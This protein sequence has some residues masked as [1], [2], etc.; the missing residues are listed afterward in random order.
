MHL[1]LNVLICATVTL[2]ASSESAGPSPGPES[3]LGFEDIDGFFQNPPNRYR[4]IQYHGHGFADVPVEQMLE[5]G[6][7]GVKLFM[8]SHEYLRSDHGWSQMAANI[9]KAKETGMQVWVGDDNGYPSGMAGGL[10]VEADPAHEV[11]GLMQVTLSGEG[12][13]AIRIELPPGAERFVHAA[14]H[15]VA[16]G[17]MSP[18][19]IRSLQ[20]NEDKIEDTGIEGPWMVSAFALK[21]INEG[22]QAKQTAGQFNT[23]GRYANLLNA[24]AMETFVDLTHAEYARRLGPLVDKIDVFYT[25]EP[26]LMTLWFEGG[27]RP[28]GEAF[29]PWDTTL[30]ARFLDEHG[31][32]LMPRLAALFGGD[33]EE[34]RLTRRHFYQTV[35]NMLAD[36]FSGRIARWADENSVRS[37]GH[38][39][40]EEHTPMHVICSADFLRVLS[41]QHVPGCDIPMPDAGDRWNYWMPKYVASAAFLRGRETASALLDPIIGRREPML[42]PGPE[43]FRRIIG[44][45]SLTGMN[46][47]TTY[48]PWSKF[49]PA[50][51]RSY[52]EYAGRLAVMLRGA[53]NATRIAMYYPIETFQARYTASP[54]F[55]SPQAWSYRELQA[56]QDDTARALLETRH[57]FLFLNADAVLDAEVRDGLLWVRGHPF[58]T[59]I[60]PGVELLP[61]AVLQKL[62]AFETAGGT[63]VWVNT[64]PQMG[65]APEEHE[66]VRNAVAEH[67]IVAPADVMRHIGRP[68]PETFRLAFDAPETGFFTTRHTRGGKNLYYL[69][70]NTGETVAATARGNAA[71]VRLYNPMDGTI[72]EHPLPAPIVME[73]HTSL[74]VVEEPG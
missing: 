50:V 55:W 13:T 33:S 36:N 56:S 15:S 45:A 41:Q 49:D 2:S 42:E 3:G 20:I 27:S 68:W 72:S 48:I 67:E 65:D 52:N 31:Y 24:S 47:I 51:Y 5:H 46:Q 11:R 4:I 57:D 29:T 61:R 18:V 71:P 60:M 19:S 23:S 40:L 58:G 64:L 25:N 1:L 7:G 14:I 59:V 6:I 73:P 22:T 10:V 21:I 53:Q 9:A 43:D 74:F 35:G 66:T 34:A 63:V 39:L 8:G 70:N 30:P 54:E 62:E 12:P 38:L 17:E 28:G 32:D 69:V 16:N 37:G 26:N 44:M